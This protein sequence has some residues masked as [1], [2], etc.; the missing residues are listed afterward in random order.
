M[1]AVPPTIWSA[2]RWIAQ[3]AWMNAIVPP[4]SM[5]IRT[6]VHQWPVLSAPQMPQNAP[7]SIIPSSPMF[8][9]PERSENMP[10]IEAK[11]SGVAKRRVAAIRA[12][13]A[14]TAFRFE[15]DERVPR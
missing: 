15:T 12:D 6:P 13:Q 8:T 9:T 7:I 11:A 1:I 3:T 5:A 10:P 4:A 2:R 14:K